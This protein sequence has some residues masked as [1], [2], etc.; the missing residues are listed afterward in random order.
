MTQLLPQLDGEVFITD[1]GLETSLVFH[2]GVELPEFAAFPLLETDPGQRALREWFEPFIELAEERGVGIVID[3]PTWRANPDWGAKLGYDADGLARI[4][5]AG[6]DFGRAVRDSTDAAVIVNGVVGPRGD[7]YVLEE[8]MTPG[9]AAAYHAPQIRA[10]AAA[11]ADMVSGVTITS[12][13]EAIGIVRAA[14]DAQIP[15]AI[16]FTLETDGRLPSGQELRAAIEQVDDAT[17]AG[18]AYFMINC[19]HPTHFA[20]AIDDGAAWTERIVGI[21]AN[22]SAKSHEELDAADELDEGDPEDLAQRYAELRTRL[23]RV[24]VIGGCCGTDLR[25]VEAVARV[26]MD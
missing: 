5:R 25:H 16:S 20:G 15:A 22:A 18:A 6:V 21:R 11:G 24:T 12:A 17:G 4:N 14:Q 19:A 2:H 1:G 26:W 9:E 13:E 23:P 3:T 10:F 7:G 8:A